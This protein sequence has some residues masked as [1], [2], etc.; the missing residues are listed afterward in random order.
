MT[1]REESSTNPPGSFAE[2]FRDATNQRGLSLERLTYHLSRR[3]HEL[4]AATLSYWRTGRSV[5]QR[6]ASIAA[7]GAL[8]EI[9]GVDRGSLS[10]LVP[11][12]PV[13]R[14]DSSLDVPVEQYVKSGHVVADMIS[15]IGL[16]WHNGFE[17]LSSHDYIHL[18]ADG[19]TPYRA[20]AETL[21]D[22]SGAG[23]TRIGFVSQPERR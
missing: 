20:V 6:S 19:T 12:R 2:A 23:L 8:E 7:L 4:S 18:R 10:G 1:T 17:F 11:P 15:D 9:L 5:P 16:E 22:A 21:A 3:G 13:L 14:G